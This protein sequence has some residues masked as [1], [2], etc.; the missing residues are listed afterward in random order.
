LGGLQSQAH[1]GKKILYDPHLNLGMVA[2]ACHPSD[3][4][5]LFVWQAWAKSDTLSP[6][7]SEQKV[8]YT[9]V[10]QSRVYGMSTSG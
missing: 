7:S 10:L 2:S 1:P 8:L 5:E 4:G 3:S 9:V 6:K